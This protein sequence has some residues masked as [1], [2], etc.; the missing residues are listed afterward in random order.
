MQKVSFGKLLKSY[1]KRAGFKT[2]ASFADALADE[3]LIYS[4]SILSRWQKDSRL[5]KDRTVFL[6]ILKVLIVN[7]AI[8]NIYQAN[9]LL[10]IAGKG[11]LST[12]EVKELL[13]D[14]DLELDMN[15]YEEQSIED[16]EEK[17]VKMSLVLPRRMDKYLD[18]VSE[19]Y[20]TTKAEVFRELI[21]KKIDS[22]FP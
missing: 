4:E 15:L 12:E 19:Q 9:R 20:Q 5:P 16:S 14:D 22:Q 10:S 8:I 17:L 1:R 2:L 7:G 11:F 6:I 13:I 3:G 21:N 18:W